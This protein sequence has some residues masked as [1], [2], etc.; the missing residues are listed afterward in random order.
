MS[1]EIKKIKKP[2][3]ENLKLK[4]LHPMLM[5]Y[6]T[7]T[8]FVAPTNV[9][10]TNLIINLIDR[11]KFYKNKFDK[12]ILFSNTYHSDAIFKSCKSIDEENV[13]T[14][15]DDDILQE[16]I[17]E[18]EEAIKNEEPINTLIIFDDIIQQINKNKSLLNSLV[19]R[20]RHYYITIWIT[21]QKYSRVSQSIRN[22]ISYYI[23]FGIKNKKEKQFIIDELSNNVNE[24]DFTKMWDY[25]LDNQ[26]YNFLVISVKDKQDK[27]YR[28]QFKSYI[29]LQDMKDT[30]KKSMIN[31]IIFP[32]DSWNVGSAR[33][34]LK[35]HKFPKEVKVNLEHRPNFIT[36]RL[37]S[38]E[39]M[40]KL[41]YTRYVTKKLP[42]GVEIILAYKS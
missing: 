22:N 14:D 35:E 40:T 42:N 32:K 1:L 11:P 27:M 37:N 24:E 2:E 15:Y 9:G 31:S 33:K 3:D 5:K 38:P 36:F 16:I 28:K 19:M 8:L 6:F 39:Y 29:M 20:N 18:Q 21:T 34:W 4:K 17:D 25:A 7:N 30:D 12:I 23:L 10:K 26:N 13:Y 41:G